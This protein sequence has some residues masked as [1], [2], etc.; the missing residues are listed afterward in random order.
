M[1]VI[2]Y[3]QG[4]QYMSLSLEITRTGIGV[5]LTVLHLC[6]ALILFALTLTQSAIGSIGWLAN[7]THPQIWHRYILFYH[8]TTTV[9]PL[10]TG[11]L[12]CMFSTT[13][14]LHMIMVSV[15][16]PPTKLPFTLTTY[17]HFPASSDAEAYE[18]AVA[19]KPSNSHEL[20]TYSDACWGSQIGNAVKAG[21]YLPHFKFRSSMSGAIIFRSGGPIAW[22]SVRQDKRRLSVPAKQ[23]FGLG[24]NEASS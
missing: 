24:T 17:L 8:P 13:S 11:R 2:R 22:K 10:V 14:I 18:D 6:S 3:S 23:R 12:L 15:L 7:S 16:H 20:T 1:G 21:V 9:R 19:P 5:S 4:H